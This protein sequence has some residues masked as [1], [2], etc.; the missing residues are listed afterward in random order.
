VIAEGVVAAV[1]ESGLKVRWCAAPKAPMWISQEDLRGL[2]AHV[3]SA[4]D[5]DGRGAEDR[6]KAIKGTA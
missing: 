4:D 6:Q 3:T 1:K 5:L 2:Q